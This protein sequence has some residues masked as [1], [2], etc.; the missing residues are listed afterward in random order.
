MRGKL[1][2]YIN[3]NGQLPTSSNKYDGTETV[4]DQLEKCNYVLTGIGACEPDHTVWLLGVH[5]EDQ[6][7]SSYSMLVEIQGE[8]LQFVFFLFKTF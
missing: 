2:W 8:T 6:R 3:K 4:C 5:N 7:E 1:G